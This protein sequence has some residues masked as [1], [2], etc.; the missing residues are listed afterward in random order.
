MAYI[1]MP[2]RLKGIDEHPKT[3]TESMTRRKSGLSVYP[4]TWG[5]YRAGGAN[6]DTFT[7]ILNFY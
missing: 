3:G 5:F 2:R 6:I 4:T 7:K 1:S